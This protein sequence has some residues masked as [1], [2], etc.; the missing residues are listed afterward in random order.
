MSNSLK[1]LHLND[2][3]NW[4][5]SDLILKQAKKF[6]KFNIIEFI[7]NEKWTYEDILSKGLKASFRLK[8][9]GITNGDSIVVMID[10]PKVFIPIWLGACFLGITF[11]A[12]NTALRGDVLKHQIEISKP[13]LII[14]ENIYFKYLKQINWGKKNLNILNHDKFL[15][16]KELL[17]SEIHQSKMED[18]SCV[19]FTSGTSGPAKGVIMPNAHCVLFAIG[20]IENYILDKKD[21]FY[22]CLPLFHANGLFMQLLACIINRTKA[23]I[24]EKFSASNWLNDI[25]NYK[26]THTNMLGAVAAFVVAQSPTKYDKRHKLKVIGSAPLPKEPEIIFR[27][28]FGVKEVLP[29]Y[30]MTEVNI[31]VYGKLGKKGNGTCGEVYSKYFD[32]EV[33]D[34]NTDDKLKN[35][36]VGEIMVRPKI[37]FGFMQGYLGMPDKSFEAYRNFWFHT[38]DAGFFNKKNQLIFVDR[39]KDCIRRRGENISSYEVEQAFLKIPQIAE[40]AAFAVPAKDHGQED[41]VMVALMII[42]GS[43]IEYSKWI[44]KV[45][46]DLAKFAIPLYLRVMKSFPKTQTGKIIKHALRTEGITN[47]TWK[48]NL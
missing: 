42:K 16:S 8:K 43:K 22:I 41:E 17:I 26:I 31:P 38:G 46:A 47:D 10:N 34:T 13:K 30:G 9:N 14:T 45:S 4:I 25:I 15:L 7:D 3:K 5:I 28:R 36:A 12:L 40:A 37:S 29:L 44:N 32:V 39:I 19:M 6:P 20:T 2:H 18:I 33:R 11:V 27:K 1:E 48:N 24:R 23:V 35:G 21:I